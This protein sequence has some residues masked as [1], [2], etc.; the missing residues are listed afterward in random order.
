MQLFTLFHSPTLASPTGDEELI[1]LLMWTAW[2]VKLTPDY[3]DVG[4]RL[5]GMG[6]N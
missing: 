3:C 4:K 6:F 2:Q 5:T 1:N